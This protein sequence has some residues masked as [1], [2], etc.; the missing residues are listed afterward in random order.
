MAQPSIFT[1]IMN[2]ELKSDIVYEDD[3]VVAIRDINPKAPIHILIVPREP[4]VSVNEFNE[5]NA[6]IAGQ[7][8]VAAAKVAKQF[9]LDEKGYR[10]VIN[11]GHE[12][13]QEIQHV[14]MHLLGGRRLG[15]P[16]G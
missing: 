5:N 3:L 13:G 11:N 10:L 6:A 16:P 15:W 14:H 1:R 12:G 7:M 2:G 9:G 4:L 8:L